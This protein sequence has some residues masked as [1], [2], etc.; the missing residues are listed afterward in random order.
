[1]NAPGFFDRGWAVFPHDAAIAHWAAKARPVAERQL[2]D[3]R[4]RALWLRCGGTWFA[5]VNVF[6]N[7][8]TG[9]VPGHEI[10]A[11][12]GPVFDAIRT[13]LKVGDFA[14]DAAQISVCLPGYPQPWEG[15]SDAAFG[16]R[17]NRDAAH[18]DGLRRVDPGRRRMLGEVHGFI[19]GIPLTASHPDAAPMVVYEGS[20]EIMRRAF[21]TRLAGIAPEY[22]AQEDVTEVYTAA[23]REAFE[24]C[25]RVPLHVSPGQAYLVHRLALHGVAPWTDGDGI[26]AIAYFRPDIHPGASPQW[27]LTHP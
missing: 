22:W 5:G 21:Q 23:R 11:L 6:P 1:M 27:W 13:T 2:H 10:P 17:L 15:E 25:R 18:V 8:A 26:R 20:H 7:D 24:T 9:A 19:L 14:W 4:L 16:F 3:P 12:D